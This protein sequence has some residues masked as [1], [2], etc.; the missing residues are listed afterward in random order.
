MH[1]FLVL[2]GKSVWPF[3]FFF[4]LIFLTTF[5]ATN[6][7]PMFLIISVQHFGFLNTVSILAN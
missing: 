6:Q 5:R 2:I 3:I 4:N 1:K 7:F